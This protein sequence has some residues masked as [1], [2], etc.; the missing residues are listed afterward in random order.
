MVEVKVAKNRVQPANSL[1]AKCFV[2]WV[3]T[4]SELVAVPIFRSCT[5]FATGCY[6]PCGV[7]LRDSVV[8]LFPPDSSSFPPALMPRGQRHPCGR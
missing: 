8:S 1:Q 2:S 6:I 7:I 5:T 4:G 3:M